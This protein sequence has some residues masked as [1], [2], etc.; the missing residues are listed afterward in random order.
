MSLR[1]LPVPEGLV[2]ERVD[3]ALARMTGLS[4][5]RVGE[6]CQAGA[7]LRDGTALGKSERL[8][9]GDLLEVDMPDP[10]P[11]EPVA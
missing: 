7:V 11:A 2:G 3:A 1:L 6:L 5:T 8:G 4:R 10:R 9:A